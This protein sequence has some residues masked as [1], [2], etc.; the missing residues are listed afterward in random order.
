[1]QTKVQKWGNSLA[2]RIPSAF[3]AEI[4]FGKDAEIEMN[5]VDGKLIVTPT[6]KQQFSLAALLSAIDENN[7]HHETDTG[8]PQGSEIW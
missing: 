8:V 6:L 4:G 7:I 5:I 2:I 3:V 1:M